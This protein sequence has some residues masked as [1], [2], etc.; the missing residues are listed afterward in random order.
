MGKYASAKF[1]GLVLG[2]TILN[3]KFVKCQVAVLGKNLKYLSTNTSD[4]HC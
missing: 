1:T 4:E 2:N 3:H